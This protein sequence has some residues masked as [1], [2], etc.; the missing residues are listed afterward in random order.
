MT[1][2]R[3]EAEK[4]CN[5]SLVGHSAIQHAAA[6]ATKG[7][8]EGE[9]KGKSSKD[10]EFISAR[11]KL[12]VAQR[13]LKRCKYSGNFSSF[14]F[15]KKLFLFIKIWLIVTT[16]VQQEE[17]ANYMTM[18]DTLDAELAKCVEQRDKGKAMDDCTAKTLFQM[19]NTSTN[20][21]ISGTKKQV[22]KRKGDAALNEQYY[23]IKF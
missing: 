3:V 23:Q 22:G 18:F 6:M 11:V 8:E 4:T 15:F 9:K 7:V 21:F 20:L 1:T 14:S 17:Y 2:D 5:V 12:R 16:D 19:R 13:M 10:S